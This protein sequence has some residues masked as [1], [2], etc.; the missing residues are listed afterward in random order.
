MKRIRLPRWLPLDW[1]KPAPDS[2]AGLAIRRGK[3]PWS[4][5]IHL[6]WSMWLFITPVF[7][8][9]YTLR[10][11]W[12]TLL[13]YPIFILLYALAVVAPRRQAWRYA[14]GMIVM[15]ALLLRW[16]PSGFNYF[17][18]GCVMLRTRE[19]ASLAR[20]LALLWSINAVFVA[21][22]LWVGYPWQ[23]IIWMPAV[24]T[25]IGV[26][27]RVE[28]RGQQKDAELLL[29]HAEVRRLAATAER[30]RIGRDLHDLLGHTLSLITLKLELSRKLFDRDAEASRRELLE[31]ERV[32]R[33]ALAEVRSAVTGIRA[34]DLAAEL[35]A[36][37]L[38]LESSCVHLDYEAVPDD[39]D[40]DS[41][42][43]LALVLREAVTN[44]ARHAHADRVKVAFEHDADGVML[45]IE[46]D[47]RGGI[48]A[49]GNGLAGMRERV[50]DLGG[51]LQIDS[52]KGGGTRVRVR[53]PS[54][55]P[56]LEIGSESDDAD[57][58]T[59]P[60]QAA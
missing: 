9:G 37:R 19:S 15:S 16:Y 43:T 44:V 30:E 50:A 33:H 3:S 10:W 14:I 22:A 5:G 42:R 47:G 36:A 17:V 28:R 20:Y 51:T 8:G 45:R 18:F 32:A 59:R 35:A 26:I 60:E 6:L 2:I 23:S 7:S 57:D 29:S 12:L 56:A 39:L 27:V 31:A 54:R 21:A 40:R 1:L 55:A 53:I 38:M 24:T 11:L 48:T 34:T 46:D 49:D 58:R 52:P 13:T 25:V 4:E 41:E